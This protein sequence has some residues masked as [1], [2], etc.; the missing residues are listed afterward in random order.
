[1]IGLYAYTNARVTEDNVIPE[2]NRLFNV[3]YNSFGLW[4]S[5]EIQGGDLQGLGMGVGVNYVGDRTW[6]VKVAPERQGRVFAADYL[7][8]VV[9]E[10]SAGLSAGLLADQIFEPAM[11]FD[12]W[13]VPHL[14]PLVGMG[15]GSGMALLF[16]INAIGMVLIGLG[17]LAFPQLRSAET[18]QPDYDDQ[19][20]RSQQHEAERLKD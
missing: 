18:L 10:A 3:P 12:G 2:G 7:I 17:G 16:G 8:G 9:I 6:Y 14:G 13:L 11:Q 4:T 15:A 20:D 1:M 5:Y 19:I